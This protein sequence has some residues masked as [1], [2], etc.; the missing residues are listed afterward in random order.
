MEKRRNTPSST[1]KKILNRPR[2][3]PA[4]VAN[5]KMASISVMIVPPTAV[6]EARFFVNPNWETEG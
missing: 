2:A 6:T 4:T 1:R 3:F 5:I